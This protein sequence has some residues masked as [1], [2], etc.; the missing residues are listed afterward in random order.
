MRDNQLYRNEGVVK[1]VSDSLAY[2]LGKIGCKIFRVSEDFSALELF[3]NFS[4]RKSYRLRV[5][6][7]S[8]MAVHE[9]QDHYPISFVQR[10]KNI[11][12]ILESYGVSPVIA[13]FEDAGM[14]RDFEARFERD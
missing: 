4:G 3:A 13:D 6:L 7:N 2:E 14:G 12:D 10:M 1:V 9:E 8:G 11:G 5:C